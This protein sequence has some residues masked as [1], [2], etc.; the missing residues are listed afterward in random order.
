MID[1]IDFALNNNV[2]IEILNE[3]L[4]ME[5]VKKLHQ[6]DMQK[7]LDSKISDKRMYQ[8]GIKL[9]STEHNNVNSYLYEIDQTQAH[10]DQT[11]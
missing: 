11:L 3:H 4:H 8:K 5:D 10:T 2:E 6:D 9:L 7:N 1:R